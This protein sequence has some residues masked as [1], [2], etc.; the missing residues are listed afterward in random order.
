MCSCCRHR[1]VPGVDALLEKFL[2]I[3]PVPLADG[4]ADPP[5]T[6]DGTGDGEAADGEVLP[7]DSARG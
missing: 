6:A 3:D 2:A 5:T 7:G 1:E 4:S